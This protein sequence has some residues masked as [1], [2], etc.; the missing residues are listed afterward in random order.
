VARAWGGIVHVLLAL[1]LG[2]V[3][4]SRDRALWNRCVPWL[5]LA[6]VTLVACALAALGR[7]VPTNG[8]YALAPRYVSVSQYALVALVA[9]GALLAPRG[10]RKRVVVVAVAVALAVPLAAGW[11]AGARGLRAWQTA[12]L[13][14]R[15]SLLFIRDFEP[16][17]ILRLDSSYDAVRDNAERMDRHGYLD[18]P[19]ARDARPDAFEMAHPAG[20]AALGG[21][22]RVRAAGERLVVHGRAALARGRTA[23]GVLLIVRDDAGPRV[24]GVGDGRS[25][26]EGA[27]YLH[28]HL[29]SEVELD[30][31]APT[32]RWKA[33]LDLARLPA[34]AALHVEAYAVDAE[35]MLLHRLPQD[36]RVSRG[37]ELRVA[38][39]PAQ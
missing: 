33:K 19:L 24:V 32:G 5:V 16:R 7:A 18:P 37:A 29:H 35:R 13:E 11:L 30:A 1:A 23:H 15:T 28:D 17:Y 14:A 21:I 31:D 8:L 4:A 12:R 9:L 25:R 27:V 39:V 3:L 34:A 22:D 38:L 26:P 10:P 36:I 20:H 2:T 6:G